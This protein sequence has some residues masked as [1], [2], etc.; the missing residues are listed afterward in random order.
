MV[1]G[2]SGIFVKPSPTNAV[3]SGVGTGNFVWGTPFPDSSS[4]SFAGGRFDAQPNTPFK[5]GKLTYHNGTTSGGEAS[6]VELDVPMTFDNVPELNFTYR[7]KPHD[8]DHAK[9]ER[10]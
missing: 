8:S 3:V 5:I 7:A 4:L 1:G 9:Y 2:D 10:S 6:G